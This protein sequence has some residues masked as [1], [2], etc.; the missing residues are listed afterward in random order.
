MNYIPAACRFHGGFM[1]PD[2]VGCI[3]EIR[4]INWSINVDVIL[5][6]TP[7]SHV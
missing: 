2:E 1:T 4:C 6:R 7:K 3:K 5:V